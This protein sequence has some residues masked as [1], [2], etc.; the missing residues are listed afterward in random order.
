MKLRTGLLLGTAFLAGITAGPTLETMMAPSLGQMISSRA[1]AREVAADKNNHSE[2][3][4]LLTLFGTVLDLVRAEYVEPVSDKDLINNA[5]DGMVGGLDPHSSYMNEKQFK[6]MQIQISGKFGGLGVQVQQQNGHIRVVSPIDGTPAA[7]A[8]MKPGDY[9]TEVDGKSLAGLTLDQAVTRMRGDPGT[10]ITLTIV[11]AKEPKPI[12]LTMTREIVHV[13]VVRSALYGKIGYI[14]IS[15]FDDDTETALHEAFDKLKKKAGGS[16]QGLVLD[17][18]LNP[19]G[20]LDQA[21]AVSNDFIHEGEIVS[22]R[23]RHAENNRRWDAKGNDF[24]GK[25]P[26]VVLIDGG[27]ASASEIVAG[28]LQD[29]RRAVIVGEKSF[30]KGSV[31]SLIPVPGNGAVRLTT[32]RYYTPS[33]RSIQALGISP[34]IVVKESKDDDGYGYR[35]A[36]L[37]HIISNSGGNKSKAPARTDLPAISGSIPHAPPENWPRF[38]LAKPATDFQLQQGLRVVRAMASLPDEALPLGQPP[39]D[40]PADKSGDKSG[41]KKAAMTP[42]PSS[43]RPVPKSAP[44]PAPGAAPSHH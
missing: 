2:T 10:K 34:D 1:F 14:R 8:G 9:I 36:D 40:K 44:T 38:E 42:A 30:G 13:Q 43:A 5:L 4:R 26:V 23:G 22:I 39:A 35:E 41:D 24:A 18:R 27:S 37:A 16:L 33:G 29:H 20:K 19:G 21:I 11:R 17:L 7:R 31:Q 28:A 3:L 25:L 32:A 15:E 12:K 6:E